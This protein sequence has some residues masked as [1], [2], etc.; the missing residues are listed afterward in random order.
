M[1]PIEIPW[2]QVRGSH[3]ENDSELAHIEWLRR[4]VPVVEMP[5]FWQG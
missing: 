1:R 2:C 3:Q 4:A 5:R